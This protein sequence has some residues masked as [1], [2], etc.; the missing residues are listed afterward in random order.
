MCVVGCDVSPCGG[1][2]YDGLKGAFGKIK[3][4]RGRVVLSQR[5]S[6]HQINR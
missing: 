5:M 6:Y 3:K 2:G 4:E 1:R